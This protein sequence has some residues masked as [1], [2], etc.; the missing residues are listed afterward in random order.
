M[1]SASELHKIKL[2]LQ[3]SGL[4]RNARVASRIMIN[5]GDHPSIS[6]DEQVMQN[7]SYLHSSWVISSHS[8]CS[9][10]TKQFHHPV[11]VPVEDHGVPVPP[12]RGA[13]VPVHNAGDDGLLSQSSVNDNLVHQDLG[14]IWS[15]SVRGGTLLC[16]VSIEILRLAFQFYKTNNQTVKLN[17]F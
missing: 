16:S 13:G 11:P 17:I 10:I 9:P 2:W 15:E 3:L 4:N 14:F 5:R 8:S 6:Y 7:N 1:I 12:D